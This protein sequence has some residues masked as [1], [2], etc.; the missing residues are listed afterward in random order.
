[1]QKLTFHRPD[2]WHLH[3]RDG[4]ILQAV[5]PYT[6]RVFGR[7]IIMPN[8]KPPVTTVAAAKSYRRRIM[9]AL[10]PNST[11]HP[12]MTCYLSDSLQPQEIKAGVEAG[13]FT[14][15]KLYP[16]GA[17]TNSEH[18]VTAIRNIWPLLETMQKLGL[19]L[20]L[21]GEVVDPEVDIFDRE[22]VFIERVLQPL[23][24]DFPGL[25][26]VFE[27]ITTQDAVEFTLSQGAR[28]GATITPHHLMINRNAIFQD[29]IRP[30]LYCLPIAKR[31]RHRLA[32]QKAA[33]SGSSQFFLGT[34]SAPHLTV[35]KESNCG[36]AGIFNSPTAL[37]CVAQVFEQEQ[38]LD[39]LEAFVSLNGAHFYGLPVNQDY[40]TLERAAP[41]LPAEIEVAELPAAK[42]RVFQPPEPLHWRTASNL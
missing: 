26:V 17:T 4:A 22:A 23:L 38:A 18:G 24:L 27:H 13:I 42:I 33:V 20:L 7:A 29:G 36:C 28:V 6:T 19:P 32:L 15:A 10:P 40:I 1:M 16:A 25:K 11:F 34:D 14:A 12:L 21:H 2:D 39:K 8:L 9:A 30:H 31:E 3:L 37:P 35:D 41:T 5:L